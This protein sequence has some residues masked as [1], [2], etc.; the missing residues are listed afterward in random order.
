MIPAP[1][2]VM[3]L[4]MIAL[5]CNVAGIIWVIGGYYFGYMK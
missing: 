4:A 2:V 3:Y 1:K 5:A